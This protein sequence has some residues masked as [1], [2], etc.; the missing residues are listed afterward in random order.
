MDDPWNIGYIS[1][2]S[3]STT[4]APCSFNIKKLLGYSLLML[5]M[6]NNKPEAS[7]ITPSHIIFKKLNFTSLNITLS[8]KK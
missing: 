1:V 7:C 5:N 2:A 3:F 8:V 4:D 6:Q